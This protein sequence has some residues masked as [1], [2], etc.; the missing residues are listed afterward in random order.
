M[1]LRIYLEVIISTWKQLQQ[2]LGKRSSRLYWPLRTTPDTLLLLRWRGEGGYRTEVPKQACFGG[3]VFFFSKVKARIAWLWEILPGSYCFMV[4]KV[5]LLSFCSDNDLK[6][7]FT[8]EWMASLTWI[9]FFI[10]AVLQ[11]VRNDH[12]TDPWRNTE[13]FPVKQLILSLV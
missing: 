10:W 5:C 1:I 2:A 6:V 3:N 4:Q 11:E 13:L 7:S 8:L 12:N 9:F